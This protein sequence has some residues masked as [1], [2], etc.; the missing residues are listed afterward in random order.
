MTWQWCSV[1]IV[2]LL[3][4]HSTEYTVNHIYTI[5][6]LAA[7]VNLNYARAHKSGVKTV[8]TQKDD[9]TITF[10]RDSTSR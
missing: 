6:L 3:L 9:N 2:L 8:R 5:P 1:F 10:S 7:S 4:L